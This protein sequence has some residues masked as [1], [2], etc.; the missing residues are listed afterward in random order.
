MQDGLKVS[1]EQGPP[2][3]PFRT[4]TATKISAMGGANVVN[5]MKIY[6]PA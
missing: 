3:R 1:L 2:T 6:F 4:H 5:I